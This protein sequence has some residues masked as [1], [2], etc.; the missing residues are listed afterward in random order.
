MSYLFE[1]LNDKHRIPVIDIFNHYIVSGYA[2]YPEKKVSYEFFDILL[3][4]TIGYPAFSIVNS[5]PKRVIGFC[6]LKPYHPFPVF[7]EAAEITY[8]IEPLEVGKGIGRKALLMLENKGR[9]MG[10]R[11]LLASISSLNEQSL[12]FHLKNG[13]KECGR[14][15]MIGKKMGKHFDVIWMQKEVDKVKFKV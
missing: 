9:I 8:F 15:E 7:K 12:I 2:A 3:E 1:P 5:S 14:F 10:I 6:Y 11:Q 13:F 4:K